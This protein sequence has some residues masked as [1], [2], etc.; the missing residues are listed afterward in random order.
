MVN[1]ELRMVNE[2]M[3]F[4]S[5]FTI[6][7][8]LFSIPPTP[9]PNPPPEYRGR[10]FKALSRVALA[11]AII[12]WD[13]CSITAAALGADQPLRLPVTRDLWVSAVDKEA[14]ANLGASPRLKLKS[15]Q[16]MSII[17]LDPSS[18]KGRVIKSAQLHLHH[19]SGEVLHR[20]TVSSLASEWIEGTSGNYQPQ[21]GSSCFN[22]RK[23]PND[24]WAYPG[25]DLTAVMLGNGG[26]IWNSADATPPDAE[27]WQTIEV[28]PRV[29]AARVAGVSFGFVLFDD[30][31][32]EWTREGEK[33]NLRLFPNRFVD[34]RDSRKQLAPYFVIELGAE[35]HQAPQTAREFKVDTTDLAAGEA[36]VS[37]IA[38]ADVGSAGLAGFLVDV[39]GKS[40]PRYLIPAA[41]SPDARVAM[42]LRDLGLKAGQ[43]VKLTVRAVDGAG[44]IGAAASFDLGVSD[45]ELAPLPGTDG[46]PFANG[47]S[48]PKLA[49]AEIAIIDALD[50]VQPTTGQMIPAQAPQYFAANHLWDGKHIRL[51]AARN[52]FV[53]FQVLVRGSVKEL[54]ATLEFPVEGGAAQAQFARFRYVSSKSGPV[55]DPLVPMDKGLGVPDP[56]DAMP[57]QKSG[58]FLCEIYVP[59][60]AAAGEHAGTLKL[61]AGDQTLQ[62]PLTLKVWDFTLPDHL[63]FIPEMNCYGLPSNELDYYRL[64]HRNRVVINRVPYSQGGIV[65]DG[66]A[67]KWDPQSRTLDFAQWDQRF[68][69]LLDGAAFKDLPRKN[70]PLEIFYLPLHENWPTPME[71]N[72][73]GSYWADQAF[74]QSY[75][76]NFIAASKQFAQHFNSRKYDDTLFLGF[77][78]GK[79]NYKQNG[80]SRGSSPWL[81]DEPANFQD[82]WALHFFGE[83]F[84]HGVGEVDVPT[85]GANDARSD[86]GS[87]SARARREGKLALNPVRRAKMLFRCDISRPQWQRD[88][89]DGVLNYNVVS[90]D[91]FF[92]YHRMVMDRK[93]RFGQVVIPY[94]TTNDPA[95]S[96]VQAAAWCW[97][98]WTAGA[99]GVLPWQVIG[100]SNSWKS[101]D[102][103]CLFYPGGP[104]GE[105]AP[106]PSIRLKAYLRGEQDVEYL[107]MLSQ[108]QKQSQSIF[109][110]RVRAALPLKGQRRGTGFTADED[111]GVIAF[112]HLRPQ[113]LWAMRVRIGEVLS[114]MHPPAR[115][116]LVEFPPSKSQIP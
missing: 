80:W 51:Q 104:A 48:L 77:F 82:F 94:G 40:V 16:E 55:G 101:A 35:D 41:S 36:N 107:V 90:G 2:Q 71:G 102:A 13:I 97:A 115:E 81:L 111:A 76:D 93:L 85:S 70:V 5:A 7:Y 75:R 91:A 116:R 33:F 95:D 27:G 42:H 8:S 38:P 46:K 12:V 49:D 56:D 28:D 22:F 105:K 92:R 9:L 73:N 100:N 37:W 11:L 45:Q 66:C 26:T 32:S 52:E 106:I 58:S 109:G 86:P 31:G 83:L 14:N 10:G 65:E 20:V 113:D 96:N 3:Q 67:P 64:A 44:N 103:T 50:K 60:D 98:S 89:M 24:A 62:I 47:G 79:N 15:I 30:T 43:N 21:L 110:Q 23:Y 57:D 87:R 4:L 78:N 61:T 6:H 59:H 63:S 25:S 69:P 1:G 72:Y 88:L 112:D 54:K 99:D 68:G 84:Q 17:D 29:V 108:L 74:P 34:S 18:L 114:G 39:H 53:S 19:S